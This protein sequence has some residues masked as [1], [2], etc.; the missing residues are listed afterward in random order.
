M[1]KKTSFVVIGSRLE[2]GR[3]TELGNKYRKAQDLGTQIMNESDF[4][5]YMQEITK[6]K[7]FTLAKAKEIIACEKA[8][9]PMTIEPPKKVQPIIEEGKRNLSVF[10]ESSLWVDKYAPQSTS[11]I[12]GNN[13]IIAKLIEWIHDWE[14]VI[15]KGNKKK[16][17]FHFR[18]GMP[19]ENM[20]NPNA[21]AVLL[22]G[23]PGIGKSTAAKLAAKE[24]GY[25]IVETNA[26]D[27]RSK[28]ILEQ[29]LS[30]AVDNESISSFL[31]GGKIG[32]KDKINRKTVII[33]DEVDG[34]SGNND[35]GGIQALIQIIKNTKTPIVCICNDRQH[36]KVRSLANHC[37]DL[38]FAK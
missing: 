13:A 17:D 25:D 7:D 2:D 16:V 1:S 22:S 30:D 33:M 24:Q 19:A 4:E 18:R 32:A 6:N 15:L 29:L 21:R 35:R 36:P 14:D 31:T 34:V 23:P 37:F 11:D 38:R 10:N 3:A 5:K 28:K 12:I 27:Q 8:G 20:P 9:K 26:S